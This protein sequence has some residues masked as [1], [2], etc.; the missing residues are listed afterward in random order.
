MKMYLNCILC[1][2]FDE[3]SA[4]DAAGGVDGGGLA[5]GGGAE[6]GRRDYAQPP[7]AL[8]PG[9]RARERPRVADTHLAV[10]GCLRLRDQPAH[11]RGRELRRVQ[12]VPVGEHDLA[13][14][15]AYLGDVD[16]LSRGV[17]EAPALSEGEAVDAAV[18]GDGLAVI[19]DVAGLRRVAALLQPGGVIPAGDEAELHACL[20][21][22]S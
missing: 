14:G 3:A 1:I 17:A 22:T 8:G 10:E 7:A 11:V 4:E 21:Y 12:P 6:G 2:T 15:G 9:P 19:D 18:A 5:G 16:A 20:L 13:G